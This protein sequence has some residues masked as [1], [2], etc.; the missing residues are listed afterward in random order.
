ML[1]WSSVTEGQGG[2]WKTVGLRFHC[3]NIPL[4][5]PK[6]NS[7]GSS[8]H[9]HRGSLELENQ[10]MKN[11]KPRLRYISQLCNKICDIATARN[12][13]AGNRNV[14]WLKIAENQKSESVENLALRKMEISTNLSHKRCPVSSQQNVVQEQTRETQHLKLCFRMSRNRTMEEQGLEMDWLPPWWEHASRERGG[15]GV[16]T[17]AYVWWWFAIVTWCVQTHRTFSPREL[18]RRQVCGSSPISADSTGLHHCQVGHVT[19]VLM[20][21]AASPYHVLYWCSCILARLHH[22]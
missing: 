20:L 8:K 1:F 2:I 9:L 7:T 3:C 5:A 11:S 15:G 4:S 22:Y 16:V 17:S 12:C 21:Q 13:T 6:I 14:N 10:L 18:C 19:Q